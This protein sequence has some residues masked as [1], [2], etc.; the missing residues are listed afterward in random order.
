M[1]EDGALDIL[2]DV[3]CLQ[4]EPYRNRGVGRVSASLLTFARSALPDPD[5]ARLVGIVDPLLPPLEPRH[6]DLLDAVRP[7]AY[8]G[9]L[10]RPT[11]FLELSPMTHDPLF[12][13]RLLHHP[14]VLKATVV[15]DFIQMDGA[16]YLPMP[17]NRIDYRVALY[18]LACHEIFLPVSRSTAERLK[19]LLRVPEDELT[20]IGVPVDPIF[21]SSTGSGPEPRAGTFILVLGRDDPRKNVECAIR[22]HGQ[23]RQL[24]AMGISLTVTGAYPS[25]RIS[26]LRA[27][28]ARAGGRTDL[29]NFPGYLED[30]DV[31]ALYRRTACVVCLSWTAGFSL[32]LAEAMASGAPVIASAIPAHAEFIQRRDLLLPPDD[33]RAVAQMLEQ[34]VIDSAF[35][36]GIVAANQAA[37]GRFRGQDVA[38]RLWSAVATRAERRLLRPPAAMI[39]TGRRPQVAILSPLP[40]DRSGVANYTAASFREIARLVDLHVFTDTANP[41]PVAGPLTVQP[42]SALPHLSS[43]FDRVI[44]VVGNSQFHVSIFEHL[45]R[46]G[47]ACIEH[48][49]RLLGF[50]RFLLGETRCRRQ[51]ERELGRPLATGELE[52]WLS[53]E[54]AA[55]TLFLGEVAEVAEPLCLHSKL[56]A[57]LVGERYGVRPVHL[58]FCIYREQPADGLAPDAR[59]AARRRLQIPR[60]TIAIVT[61]GFVSASKAPEECISA[62]ETLRGWGYPA[63]LWFVGDLHDDVTG[64][65]R[66]AES[67]GVGAEVTFTAEY[68][69]EKTYSDFLLAA[70]VGIQLRTH[71][72]GGLSGALLDCIAVGLPTVANN[73]LADAMEAPAY[74]QRVSD[75]PSPRSIAEALAKL[76]GEREQLSQWEEQ[77]LVYAADHS[78]TRYARSL[79]TALEFDREGSG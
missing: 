29:L 42:L 22:A 11:W 72:L 4:D 79:V 33:D 62:L 41:L 13:A 2:L 25:D 16:Q 74:V 26:S 30:R 57:R 70:D 1:T 52:R 18:W 27:L 60:D 44:A 75:H 59:A 15:Y 45:L 23:S 43:R 64:L 47:G 24:Q 6:R 3:R 55:E 48:D 78:F 63:R 58:P 71:G 21:E 9:R 37:G 65:R 10:T 49:I 66:L 39:A 51:A 14:S 36:D 69:D 19:S 5:H 50:Y 28:H 56:T 35:R 20:V 76:I 12:V 8:T 17:A 40:P 46:Y 32:P 67:I 34:I 53:D 77:R 61:F 54:S 7:S 73:G 31:V 68:S 38:R